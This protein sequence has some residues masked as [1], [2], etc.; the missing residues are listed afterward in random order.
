DRRDKEK[1]AR[2]I[3]VPELILHE[4][5]RRY[6]RRHDPGHIRRCEESAAYLPGAYIRGEALEKYIESKVHKRDGYEIEREEEY[7]R[8]R[9]GARHKADKRHCFY[10]KKPE[11]YLE[12]AVPFEGGRNMEECNERCDRTCGIDDSYDSLRDER[13]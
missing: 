11:G 7:D 4:D 8:E 6:S 5:E 9:A 13:K 10:G 3:Y 12:V 2:R 1:E